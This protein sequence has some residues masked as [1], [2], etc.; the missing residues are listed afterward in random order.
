MSFKEIKA[1][2]FQKNAVQL[3]GKDWLLITAG[4]GEKFNTMT[5]SWGGLGVIWG[6]PVV[7]VYIRPQRYTKKYIDTQE[8]FTVS[9]LGKE[10]KKALELCGT[11]SGRDKDK[12]SEA[13]LTLKY[14]ENTAAFEE[15]QMIFVCKKMYRDSIKPECFLE[16]EHDSKWYPEHDYHDMY[17]AEITKVLIKE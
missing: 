7:T 17:I 3:I 10:Y 5:A 14:L 13:G 1:E 6:K 4:D 12:I 2:E 11:V 8:V 16:K 9:V 15:A